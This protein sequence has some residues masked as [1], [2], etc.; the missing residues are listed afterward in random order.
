MKFITEEEEMFWQNVFTT[1]VHGN[2]TKGVSSASDY[3]DAAVEEL[4]VRSTILEEGREDEPFPK[5]GVAPS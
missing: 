4:R 1:Y 2:P 5:I 3:A